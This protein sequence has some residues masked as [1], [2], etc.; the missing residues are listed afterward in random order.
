MRVGVLA[1]RTHVA[2]GWP[3]VGGAWANSG[4]RL[5]RSDRYRGAGA[6]RNGLEPAPH[7]SEVAVVSFSRREA[8]AA[9][10][11]HEQLE[12]TTSS[13]LDPSNP[14]SQVTSA[15]VSVTPVA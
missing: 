3:S 6:K 12:K 10:D 4:G 2:A 8:F 14:T 1:R 13:R 7:R 9:Y 11:A 15:A 5:R